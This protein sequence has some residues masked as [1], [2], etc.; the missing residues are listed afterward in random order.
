MA[1]QSGTPSRHLASEHMA[2][3][4]AQIHSSSGQES[5]SALTQLSHNKSNDAARALIDAYRNCHWRDTRISLLRALGKNG[6]ER[7][8]DFLF[9]CA[10]EEDLGLVQEAFLALGET[11]DP[12]AAT[13]LLNRLTDSPLYLKAHIVSA[14]AKVP[15]LRAA[16]S[17]RALLVSKEAA[18][19]PQLMRNCVVALSEMKDTA[20]LA[21]LI[22]MLRQ[23]VQTNG[24]QPDAT[25]LTLLSGIAKLSRNPSD[26]IEFERAFEGEMLHQQYFQQCLTQVTF[27]QQWTLEDYLGKIFFA[28]HVQ[29]SLPLEL[30]SFPA[31][32][33]A[34]ALTLFASEEKHFS[35]LCLA[36]ASLIDAERFYQQFVNCE[37]LDSL[38]TIA[39]LASL[40]LHRAPF[41]RELCQQIFETHL[42]KELTTAQSSDLFSA[43]L[44]AIVCVDK[45]PTTVLNDLL[46]APEF[47]SAWHERNKVELINAF[48]SCSL[49]LKVERSWPKKTLQQLSDLIHKEGSALVL[50]RWIRAQGE[51]GLSDLKWSDELLSKVLQSSQ[52]LSSAL[53]MLEREYEHQNTGLLRSIQKVLEKQS[54][55]LAPFLRACARLKSPERDLPSE[56]NLQ[57]AISSTR[58]EE[59]LAA[60]ACLSAHPRPTFL[61]KLNALCDP[62]RESQQ[63][64]VAAIVALRSYKSEKSVEQLARCLMSTHRVLAGRALDTLLAIEHSSARHAVVTYFVQHLADASITDKVLRSLKAPQQG[65]AQ[66][67]ALLEAA[68]EHTG[69]VVLKDDIVELAQRLR[70]GVQDSGT[71]TPN[72]DAIRSLDKRLEGK[73]SDYGKLADPIKASLRSAE[74]PLLE[75]ELFEGSVD[76]SASVV[77]YCKA[78]DL[79]LEKDFGQK[80]LFPKMEQQLHIFQNILHKA[81]LDQESPNINLVIRHFG[82]EHVFDLQSFP[83]S[84]MMM[85]SRSILSGRILR[86]R[87]QVIDGLKAWAVILMIFSGRERLWGTTQIKKD[88]LLYHQLAHKLVLLQDLRN[89]AAHR[90]TMLALAPLSEIRKEVFNVFAQMK[91]AFE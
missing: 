72:S 7:A 43:W 62:Q 40:A 64:V 44:R 10:Q 58:V 87:T 76:K 88:P 91:K 34:E 29:R 32:D 51:L 22:A 46:N 13:F 15:D 75:P 14:L 36:L 31:T 30:N 47:V 54:E 16:A 60:I 20:I 55:Q 52:L 18:E 8:I 85:I 37:K 3:L 74:L 70:F 82:A 41:A 73:I 25:A 17:L 38:S 6:S 24:H 42:K 57:T 27:R 84:K 56:E 45:D 26:L 90:Q 9:R 65:D 61:E 81:E 63:V 66:L 5:R 21:E 23:R 89:P 69:S 80:L 50:G 71:A 48:V 2:Q 39:L 79:A 35:R 19:H 67:A 68:A 86:E 28:E 12:V 77:Q 49:A 33:V 4:S 1:Q 11:S 53:L 83:S 78:I 59:Q